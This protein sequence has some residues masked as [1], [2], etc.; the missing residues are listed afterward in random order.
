MAEMKSQARDPAVCSWVEEDNAGS[1]Y[2]GAD[3]FAWMQTA[4][5]VRKAKV[6]T[7]LKAPKVSFEYSN[8]SPVVS[9]L[10]SEPGAVIDGSLILPDKTRID[11]PNLGLQGQKSV[12]EWIEASGHSTAGLIG[13]SVIFEIKTQVNGLDVETAFGPKSF[14]IPFTDPSVEAC[15]GGEILPQPESQIL[16]DGCL[17]LISWRGIKYPTGS[18]VEI[19][20]LD[21]E[22]HTLYEG[23]HPADDPGQVYKLSLKDLVADTTSLVTVKIRNRFEEKI[24]EWVAFSN[25]SVVG[26][27]CGGASPL[28]VPE[29]S[30]DCG[31][32]TLSGIEHDLEIQAWDE[33]GNLF[34]RKIPAP[35]S[36]VDLTSIFAQEN[37]PPYGRIVKFRVRQVFGQLSSD[38]S[39]EK[40]VV[41]CRDDGSKG[42]TLPAEKQ[43]PLGTVEF[44]KDVGVM[45]VP[46]Q[47]LDVDSVI[48]E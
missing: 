25:Q 40:D 44:K 12:K 6:F 7:C 1:I 2:N 8:C 17:N 37:P 11:L 43:A 33:R 46:T 35:V 10:T 15:Q 26:A 5:G 41:D 16:Q 9:W 45:E 22:G 29:F 19:Q 31:V 48:E 36:S 20:I 21:P 32:I 27:D 14:V 30:L 39:G 3:V 42:S 23:V 34:T 24:S 38:W 28:G 4:A 47:I 13:R 18:K